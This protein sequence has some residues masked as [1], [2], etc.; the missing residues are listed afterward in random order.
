MAMFNPRRF[1]QPDTLKTIEPGRLVAF[2]GLHREFL[3]GCGVIF[4]SNGGGMDCERLAT[5]LMNLGDDAPKDLLESLYVIHEMANQDGMDRL[6]EAAKGQGILIDFAPDSSP[7]DIAVQVF[8]K[9]RELIERQHANVFINRARSFLY[10]QGH[11]GWRGKF[12][13]PATSALRSLESEMDDW[14]EERKRGR[15][16]RVFLLDHGRK[17]NLVVRHGLPFRREG[18]VEQDGQSGAVYFRPES[19]DV[20]VYDRNRDELCIKAGSKAER[21]MYL[22]L[23]GKHLFGDEAHFPGDE[24][25]TLEPLRTDM[26]ASLVCSDID[27][28]AWIKLLEIG[29][30]WGGAHG[31]MEIRRAQDL[32]AAFQQRGYLLPRTARL[33]LAKF[34]VKFSASKNPRTVT[35]RPANQAMYTRDDDS[36]LLE[37]WMKRRGFIRT[38]EADGEEDDADFEPVVVG[39]GNG[40][41]AF[42]DPHGMAAAPAGG[43]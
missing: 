19:H 10:F 37:E 22:A 23:I 43:F 29:I 21:A 18:A 6:L 11:A 28:L 5:I 34:Q 12:V 16:C 36:L 35:I 26:T 2:M 39:V 20:L 13:L 7:A 25:Y 30:H 17:V 31:E 4:P 3:E 42:G 1:A 32:L 8:L 15:G 41:G 33:F 38:A 40:A 9:D 27:G 24:K 14:F